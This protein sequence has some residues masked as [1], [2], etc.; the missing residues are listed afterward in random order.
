[1]HFKYD[2]SVRNHGLCDNH[3][4]RALC[5]ILPCPD[6][7]VSTAFFGNVTNISNNAI[8]I[9]V[10]LGNSGRLDQKTRRVVTSSKVEIWKNRRSHYSFSNYWYWLHTSFNKPNWF[11]IL[12]SSPVKQ[13]DNIREY[14]D[15]QYQRT[16]PAG[17]GKLLF[18]IRFS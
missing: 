1:M 11:Y 4:L 15:S 14:V 5:A 8:N 7:G 13:I 2:S 17:S 16:Y 12:R 3:F 6:Q 10:S 9:N 18:F